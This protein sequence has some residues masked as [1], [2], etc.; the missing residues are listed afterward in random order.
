MDKRVLEDYIY[1]VKELMW[2]EEKK[3]LKA[4]QKETMDINMKEKIGSQIV[5][6]TKKIQEIKVE[7]SGLK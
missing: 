4:K 5:E 6:L 2:E 7:R 3:E 1:T